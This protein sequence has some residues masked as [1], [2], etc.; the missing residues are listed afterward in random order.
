[1]PTGRCCPYW[2]QL[3]YKHQSEMEAFER[4]E[5]SVLGRVQN[6][7]QSIDFASLVGSRPSVEDGRANTISGV[8][9]ALS[10]SG[11]RWQ[12]LTQQQ[13][14]EKDK[15]AWHQ[16][17]R[18]RKVRTQSVAIR[19]RLLQ[20]G[21]DSFIKQRNDLL[22]VGSMEKAKLRAQWRA[23]LRKLKGEMQAISIEPIRVEHKKIKGHADRVKIVPK[24]ASDALAT[25][26]ENAQKR[27]LS[28]QNRELTN[29]QKH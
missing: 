2:K 7:F 10:S 17:Q 11:V 29:K 28:I 21:W 20:R 8:F 6:T 19:K 13:Q 1:M 22:L 27:M 9:Q 12:A 18:E 23:K 15:L 26:V 5:V 3:L 14:Q 16:R 24:S 4:R 25:H